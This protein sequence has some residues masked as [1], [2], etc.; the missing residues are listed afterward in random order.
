MFIGALAAIAGAFSVHAAEFFVSPT[1]SDAAAGTFD[2]PFATALRA[3]N[4]IRDLKKAGPLPKGGVTV[5][6]RGGV[7]RV[8]ATLV[9]G[10]EDSGAPDAPISYRAWKDET[11]VLSG[12]WT[13]PADAW[14]PA[15]DPRIPADARGKVWMADVKGRGF[16]ALAPDGPCGFQVPAH[17]HDILQL[18]RNG[19]L[20]TL[21][22]HPNTGFLKTTAVVDVTN[23][24]VKADIPDWPRW[25]PAQA[26]DLQTLGYWR[27]LWADLT[28]RTTVDAA[29]GTMRLH[30]D[31]IWA[32]PQKDM[33]FYL[34]NALGA[35]DAPGEWYLDRAAGRLYVRPVADRPPSRDAYELTRFAHD[36]I[37]MKD[38][39]HVRFDGLVLRLGRR[40]GFF[41]ERVTGVR[42]EA[43]VVRDFGGSAFFLHGGR[44]CR[45]AGNVFHTFGHKAMEVSG[46]D[47]RAFAASGVVVEANDVSDTGHAQRTYMHGLS[48]NGYGLRIVRNRF[49]NLPSSAL[50]VGG[51]E[52]LIASNIVE[53]VV[54]E[55]DDQGGVDM[56]GDPTYRGNRF[57]HNIW[58]NIGRPGEY[59]RCGQAG[60]RF[61][62]AISGNFVFGNLFD[63]CSG[64]LF[65][66]VQIHA[67]RDNVIRHN[68]FTRCR[69]AV[70]FSEWPM[71]R[72][73][74]YMASPVVQGY[75]KGADVDS[76]AFK[77]RYPEFA[78]TVD[79]PMNDTVEGNIMVGGEAICTRQ[80][81]HAKV[82][83]NVRVETLPADLAS[84]VPG[85]PPLPPESALGPGGDPR[86]RRAQRSDVET[87]RM[88][89]P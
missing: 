46:G 82:S 15:D 60:I 69:Y 41:A 59:V 48:L 70:S 29:T 62:D 9:L 26:P 25:A 20:L 43:C 10:A 86:L 2:A 14:R 23:R 77:A 80:A 87:T 76:V 57:I 49:H 39:A 13:V 61:D 22:R 72:W 83:G 42:F 63:N 75:K 78:T 8:D 6:F 81:A 67:G 27:Y 53:D 19:E 28:L 85:F 56:W 45:I 12:G 1:G 66:G 73:R 88:L 71:E 74:K 33:P 40:H 44:D 5:W 52:H 38:V 47:R 32:L 21:A 31:S 64:N 17:L 3:R 18:Y 54:L 84:V 30:T 35:L 34:Q 7:H 16:D 50:G 65:G 36:F 68:V 37:R 89:A 79:T 58:R 4:A 55:S 11:P 51:N 24:I